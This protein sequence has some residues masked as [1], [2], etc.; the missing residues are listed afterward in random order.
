M[1]S[2]IL[3]YTPKLFKWDSPKGNKLD[4]PGGEVSNQCPLLRGTQNGM[5]SRKKASKIIMPWQYVQFSCQ[6]Y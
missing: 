4:Q 3:I 6:F 2:E 5:E 1:R